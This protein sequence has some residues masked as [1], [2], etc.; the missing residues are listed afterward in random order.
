MNYASQCHSHTIAFIIYMC[1]RY[2]DD[3]DNEKMASTFLTEFITWLKKKGKSAAKHGQNEIL[4]HL[5]STTFK[6]TVLIKYYSDN[7]MNDFPVF[8]I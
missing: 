1:L 4:V 6:I 5:L 7:K 3:I 2:T 8:R